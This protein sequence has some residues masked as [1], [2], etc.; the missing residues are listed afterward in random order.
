MFLDRDFSRT[1]RENETRQ[2]LRWTV[3]AHWSRLLNQG[4]TQNIRALFTMG[5]IV[6]DVIVIVAT[7]VC[8]AGV[9]QNMFP[10]ADAGIANGLREGAIVAWLYVAPKVMRKD[11]ALAHY[12]SLKFQIE[13]SFGVWVLAFLLAFSI[14]FIT[15]TVISYPRG[16]YLMFFGAGF[17][18]TGLARVALV[19]L[20]KNRAAVGALSAKRIMLV[21]NEAELASF[22]A[23]FQ[24]WSNGMRIVASSILRGPAALEEDLAFAAASARM[25]R[26]DDI[27]ILVPWSDQHTI[28]ACVNAF[29]RVPASL[30][31]AAQ[32]VL[33]RFQE[34]QIDRSGP[35]TSLNL[36]RRPLSLAQVI[37]KRVFDIV[38]A[39][40]GLIFLSPLLLMV[41]ILIKLD[42]AGPVLFR[43]RRYGF[44]QEM[45]RIFKFRSMSTMDD[46]RHIEQAK[47]G[48]PRITRVGRYL[49]R[50]NIDELPQLINVLRGEMS[51]VGPRPHALAHDQQFER[52][53]ALYARRHNVKPGITGWA[54]VNGLR[55]EI[56]TPEM[57]RRRVECDLHYIDNWSMWMDLWIIGATIVSSK[58]YR[59]AV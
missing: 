26:P 47:V 17:V 56:R 33:T 5:A 39:S 46:G 16:A 6:A 54:Q 24:P 4:S 51:L 27:Y 14:A 13:H 38:G 21:G 42:S 30:H 50:L 29:L 7:A 45:F 44:N 49:R 53:I 48:D 22:S 31:L 12:Y 41:A 23:E 35:V 43:Q 15:D 36:V 58:A 59:N 11:Y 32:P 20:A 2:L 3:P 34:A 18:T 19:S 55:G 40:L 25:L 8:C 52:T 57:M 28:D 9:Y 37:Q 1:A 10:G